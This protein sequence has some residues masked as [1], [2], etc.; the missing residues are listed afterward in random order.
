MRWEW[1]S[2]F[3][4]GR[5]EIGGVPKVMQW[6]RLKHPVRMLSSDFTSRASMWQYRRFATAPP[7]ECPVMRREQDARDGFSSNMFRSLDA[8]G[9]IIFLATERKPEW[10]RLPGSSRNPTGDE[11]AEFRLTAQSMNVWVP[12]MAKTTVF[13]SSIGTDFITIA[14]VPILQSASMCVCRSRPEGF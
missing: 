9:R 12:R 10:Q 1:G 14:L 6:I 2:G 5:R 11:G 7:A 3:W 4:R 8:T 13:I